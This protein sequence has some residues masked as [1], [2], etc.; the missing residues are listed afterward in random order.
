MIPQ[1]DVSWQTASW[2]ELLAGSVRDAGELAALLELDQASFDP[3]AQAFPLRV[4]LPYL[5]RMEKG[6]PA[7]PLLLQVLPQYQERLEQPGYHRDPVGDQASNAIP[8]LIHKY[9]GRVLLVVS[10]QCAV[11]CRYC[12][13]REFSYSENRLDKAT[14]DR[15]IDYISADS[16]IS[17]VIFSGGDPLSV[18]DR[19]LSLLVEQLAAIPHLRRLRIHSRLPIV[20]PN[21]IT[22]TCLAWMARMPTVMVVHCNHAN[23]LDKE[24]MLAVAK[25]KQA[26]VTV[27]NQSVLLRGVNDS[28]SA[29]QQLCL[30]LFDAGVLP[31]YLHVL[32]K[33]RGAA[34]FDVPVEQA[35]HLMA[36]LRGCLPGYLVPR[37]VKE[38]AGAPSKIVLG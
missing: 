22:E 13:R 12:F 1:T 16:T 10:G 26:G 35:Q 8:G 37:L 5:A 3:E 23:E 34:H 24:V 38:V 19:Q 21:R 17:E 15:V 28:V 32:D 30:A 6:N 29:Q 4:P 20:I 18:G 27:L 9:H 25:M 33:V 14:R 2:Q 36:A 31:Y 7:D 11:N